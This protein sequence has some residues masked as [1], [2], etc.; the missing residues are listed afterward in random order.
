MKKTLTLL[1]AFACLSAQ[2]L[3][4]SWGT[5]TVNTKFDGANVANV[6]GYLVYLG[7][8]ADASWSIT[9]VDGGSSVQDKAATT[10]PPVLAG[11]IT[12][13]YSQN[14]GTTIGSSD[15]FGNGSTFG[16]YIVYNDG[17]KDWY[18]FSNT[19][20]TI[21]GATDDR[22]SMT[23]ATFSFD[24]STKTE[25]AS[26]KNASAGGGWYAAVPEPSTAM[27]ALAG[28]AL[29]IKRRRA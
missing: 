19:K 15:T 5:G 7:S 1:A 10:T 4:F 12:G 22:S 20:Y 18:N 3:T 29:L 2:A 25:L 9:G 13:S 8:S 16:M 27:L 17:E 21:E 14:L 26:G 6:T 23:A 11:R 28:L 24:F